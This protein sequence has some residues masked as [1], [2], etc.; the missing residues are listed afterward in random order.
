MIGAVGIDVMRIGAVL[1]IIRYNDG[2][3]GLIKVLET[4]G[5]TPSFHLQKRSRGEDARRPARL[6]NTDTDIPLANIP[7]LNPISTAKVKLKISPSTTKTKG[8]TTVP[9]SSTGEDYCIL[10]GFTGKEEIIDI[11]LGMRLPPGD[12]EWVQC[13]NCLKWYHLLCL[14]MD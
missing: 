4:L 10:C 8:N 9:T 13:D 12:I 3:A 14:D 7:Q 6:W 2:Y 1:V 11:G 5:V